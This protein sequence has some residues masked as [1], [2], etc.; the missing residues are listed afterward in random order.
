MN[1]KKKWLVTVGVALGVWNAGSRAQAS[2]STDATITITPVATVSLAISPTTYAYGTL[3]VNTSS[4]TASALT[5]TNNGEVNVVVDKRITAESS[6]AG[7]TAGNAAAA[8]TY[9]L[10]VATAAARPGVSDFSASDHRFGALSDVTTLKG[11]GGSTP[12]LGV[13]NSVDLWFRLDVPTVVSSQ[14]SREITVR[15]TG[16]AQ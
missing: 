3:D 5:L 12:N 14:V 4:V 8:D 16:T 1:R 11:L 6:P 10:Y 7:W 9:A 2:P 13:S 15:F